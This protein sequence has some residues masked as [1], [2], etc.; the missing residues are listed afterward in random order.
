MTALY[1]VHLTET[2]KFSLMSLSLFCTFIRTSVLIV[3]TNYY[4]LQR[5]HQ[6][7]L[8]NSNISGGKDRFDK[9]KKS[10]NQ[11]FLILSK[12]EYTNG[13]IIYI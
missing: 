8:T 2:N 6:Q 10:L 12:F 9:V 11:L 4:E 3:Q 7:N 1:I 5:K 13:R